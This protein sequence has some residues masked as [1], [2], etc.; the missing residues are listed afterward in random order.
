M[1]KNWRE[2][3]RKTSERE[4]DEGQKRKREREKGMN[5][6]R[7]R[8]RERRKNSSIISITHC[9][10]IQSGWKNS[11][12]TFLFFLISLPKVSLSLPISF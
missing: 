1:R 2:R 8:E 11:M 9:L 7:E 3:E 5:D 4:R 6:K 12:T 10:L